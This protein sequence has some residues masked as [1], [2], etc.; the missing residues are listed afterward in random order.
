MFFDNNFCVQIVFVT[1]H[2]TGYKEVIAW[3]KNRYN[4]GFGTATIL[5]VGEVYT[6]DFAGIMP[7]DKKVILWIFSIILLFAMSCISFGCQSKEMT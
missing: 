2:V 7:Y 1:K 3:A 6:V 5:E 4:G